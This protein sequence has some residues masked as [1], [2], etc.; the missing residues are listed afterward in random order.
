M[1]GDILS[2]VEDGKPQRKVQNA[3]DIRTATGSGGSAA[4]HAEGQ[5]KDMLACQYPSLR[6]SRQAPWWLRGRPALE[7]VGTNTVPIRLTG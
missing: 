3:S 2:G 7:Y 1:P 4:E 6:N 5:T